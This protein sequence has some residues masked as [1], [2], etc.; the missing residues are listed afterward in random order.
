[1]KTISC[2]CFVVLMAACAKNSITGRNQLALLSESQ[3]QEMATQEYR[4]FLSE[5]KV[6]SPGSRDGEMVR[7]VG[8]RL[9]NAIQSYYSQKAALKA[10]HDLIKR[11][12]DMQTA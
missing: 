7:R 10:S 8:Q 9:V 12:R 6:V 4:A 3:L 1:M 11:Q 5:N 2:I